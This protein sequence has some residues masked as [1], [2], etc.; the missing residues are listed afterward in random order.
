MLGTNDAAIL[1]HSIEQW[2]REIPDYV[3][4]LEDKIISRKIVDTR[5]VGAEIMWDHVTHYERTGEGAQILAKGSTPKGSGSEASDVPFEMFQICDAFKINQKDLHL[6]PKLKSRDMNIILKNIHRKENIMAIRGDAATNIV[7]ITGAAAANS[8]GVVNRTA[9]WTD[10]STAKYYNDVR[11]MTDKVDPDFELRWL[12]GNKLDLNKMDYLSDDT[13]QP[14]WKQIAS[15]FGKS[16]TDPKNSWQ[17]PLG[18][19]TLPQ[20]KVYGVVQDP[21][22]A[23]FVISENPA[24]RDLGMESGGNI[25]IEMFE[26]VRMEVHNNQCFVELTVN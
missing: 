22:A 25:P 7:G 2:K 4:K 13:K 9:V 5:K 16:E 3:S 11:N 14:I 15:L 1:Q 26:W 6:D 18:N 20:G 19:L 8:N 17:V 10:P 23:E 12:V 24:L 21:D